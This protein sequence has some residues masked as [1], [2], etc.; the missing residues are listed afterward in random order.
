VGDA[1]SDKA[2]PFEKF[3]LDCRSLFKDDLLSVFLYGS[4]AGGEF[5]PGLSDCNLAIVLESARPDA[6]RAA[7][8]RLGRWRRWGLGTP[9]ILDPAFVEAG[10]SVFPIEFAE[11][12]RAH[13]VLF[14]E[15]P[16]V[17]L[18]VGTGNLRLQCEYEL[19]A[20]LLFLG[21]AYL[22]EAGSAAAVLRAAQESLKSFLIIMRNALTLLGE[23]APTGLAEVLDRVEA[24]WGVALPTWRRLLAT[25][26]AGDRVKRAEVHPLFG[27]FLEEARALVAR[28]GEPIDR[29]D[30]P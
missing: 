17:D 7:S 22:R 26:M 13:R 9:L 30:R 15:D 18:P 27:A 19:H 23:S 29:G 1:V 8:R 12:K 16:F 20:K 10:A 2:P 5:R 21:Q 14:G 6:L 24:R 3:V 4:A 11:M 28:F 25:R